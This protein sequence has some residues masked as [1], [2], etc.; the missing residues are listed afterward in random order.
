MTEADAEAATER[1]AD[2]IPTLTEALGCL[3][4]ERLFRIGDA[5]PFC[6]SKS[7][8]NIADVIGSQNIYEKM[9]ATRA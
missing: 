9:Q 2:Q 5:C 7:L 3:D 1:A 6:A 4:C 8:L